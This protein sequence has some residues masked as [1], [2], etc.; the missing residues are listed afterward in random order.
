ML[1]LY[2]FA[3]RHYEETPAEVIRPVLLVTGK[4]LIA[5]GYRPGPQFKKMLEVAEDAQ[6]D[7]GVASRQEALTLI[8]RSLVGANG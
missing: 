2:D 4:D 6:L 1:H 8:A 5:A 7:G 3:R